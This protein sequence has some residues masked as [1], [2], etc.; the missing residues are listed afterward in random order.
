MRWG[1]PYGSGKWRTDTGR[2]VAMYRKGQRVRF[3]DSR[4]RQVGPEHRNVAPAFVAA[5][6]GG[7]A[8]VG[9][10]LSFVAAIRAEIV[11]T[12]VSHA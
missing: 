12:T 9:V 1:K 3:F 11:R 7:W 4:G 6:A 5:Y 10:A 8:E 2:I